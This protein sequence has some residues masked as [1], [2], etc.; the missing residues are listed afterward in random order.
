M[1]AGQLLRLSLLALVAI[2]A[3]AAP[4]RAGVALD[5]DCDDLVVI[6]RVRTL[7]ITALELPDNV[8]GTSEYSLEVRIER[9]LRGDESRS[10]VPAVGIAHA[11]IRG[12]ADFLMVF[13]KTLNGYVLRKAALWNTEPR[14]RLAAKCGAPAS[15]SKA[16][17]VVRP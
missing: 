3:Q 17:D 11:Q 10:V 2:S 1:R 13:S 8:L 7:G 9:V 12:D 5:Y 4:P 15:V 16:D 14:P 6:A